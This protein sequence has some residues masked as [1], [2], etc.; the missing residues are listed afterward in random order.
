MNVNERKRH[1]YARKRHV[2]ELDGVFG[3][4]LFGGF[5]ARMERYKSVTIARRLP[6]RE[7]G[8]F[9]MASRQPMDKIRKKIDKKI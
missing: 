4:G 7:K 1:V 5:L 3:R 6:H 8:V 2:Y 9:M